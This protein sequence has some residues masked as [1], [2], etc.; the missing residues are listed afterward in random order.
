MQQHEKFMAIAIQEAKIGASEGEQPFGA[1]VALGGELVVQCHSIKVATC[2]CTAHSETRAVGLATKKLGQRRIP[3]AIFYATCEPC[4]MCLGAI[5]NSGIETLV[6]G[7]RAPAIKKD[8]RLAFNFGSYTP[9]RFA[10][11]VGWNLKVID[12]VLSDE[13]VAL[14][15][16][17]QVELTR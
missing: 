2:D 1:V 13:C 15:V 8:E 4:P 6:L 9:E 12:G 16:N 10:E 17:A 14:Y 7:A 5:L 11:M 3:E